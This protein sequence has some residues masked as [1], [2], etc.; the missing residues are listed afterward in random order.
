MKR[1]KFLY[2]VYDDYDKGIAGAVDPYDKE[3]LKIFR[4]WILAICKALDGKDVVQIII[5]QG[6]CFDIDAKALKHSIETDPDDPFPYRVIL[7]QDKV[8]CLDDDT[9][10]Q[11][12]EYDIN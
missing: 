1:V 10:N 12:C 5:D 8:N 4:D 9:Y 2:N 3:V 6:I 11:I 7:N